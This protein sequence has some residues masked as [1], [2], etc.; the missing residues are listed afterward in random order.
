MALPKVTDSVTNITD[1]PV[2]PVISAS[3]LQ[4]LF[5]EIGKDLKVYLNDSLTV[6]LESITD[7]SSGA[8]N[9][10]ATPLTGGTANKVQGILEEL[11]TKFNTQFPVPDGSIADIKLSNVSGQ[12]KDIVSKHTTQIS[13][14][15]IN[16]RDYGA[17]GNANFFNVS[18]KKWYQDDLYTIESTD[19]TLAFFSAYNFSTNKVR[20]I[21]IPAG[22]YLIDP[23]DRSKTSL[24][25]NTKLIFLNGA[26][27]VAKQSNNPISAMLEIVSVNNIE[28][29][30]PTI[31]GDKY[32][33]TDITEGAGHGL[34]CRSVTNLKIINASISKC[35]TDG[36]YINDVIN[37]YGFNINCDDNRRQGMSIISAKNF[38][39]EFGTFSNTNGVAPSMGIDIEP[40]NANEF[41][42]KI[43][44]RNI[45]TF[46][47]SK[48]GIGVNYNKLN[49]VNTIIDVTIENWTDDGSESAFNCIKYEGSVS[50]QSSIKIID[51]KAINNK[52]A[53]IQINGHQAYN[54]AKIILIR[55]QVYNPNTLNGTNQRQHDVAISVHSETSGYPIS[56]I[57][58][59]VEII[60]PTITM[61]SGRSILR[62]IYIGFGQPTEKIKIIDPIEITIGD[63]GTV[64]EN[65]NRVKVGVVSTTTKSVFFDKF[66]STS[67]N[68]DGT[69]IR[70][71]SGGIITEIVC[72]VNSSVTLNEFENW[73]MLETLTVVH[74]PNTNSL[75]INL[76]ATQTF[77]LPDGSVKTTSIISTTPN[78]IIKFEK[79]VENKFKITPVF[80]TWT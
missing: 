54:S 48:A 58:G 18:N 78:A 25:S 49:N 66:K 1:Q 76:P 62:G 64:S 47:N 39:V 3:A 55:P 71:F 21:V 45:K 37:F 23:S 27:L 56:L 20:T 30:N 17:V 63:E 29:I 69:L 75:T 2:R 34:D 28:L 24:L 16:V 7:G 26:K 43:V 77:Y 74:Q 59:N 15:F 80:G 33:N 11:D 57:Q 68:T 73:Y 4:A 72:T 70:N 19:D 51:V 61:A 13:E 31:V 9:I 50:E 14:I 22:N 41:L 52:Y 42:E 32:Y 60:N 67:L 5:D 40:N 12:I 38:L 46:N 79:I 8:D 65:N 44:L 35:F 10:G 36:I 6:A 53:G